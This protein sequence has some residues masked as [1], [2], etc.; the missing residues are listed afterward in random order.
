MDPSNRLAFLE[1]LVLIAKLMKLL[2]I[3]RK[4]I[5]EFVPLPYKAAHEDCK[6]GVSVQ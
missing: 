1:K 5:V 6:H 4:S 3:S 2:S